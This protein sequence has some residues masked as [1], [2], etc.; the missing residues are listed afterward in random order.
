MYYSLYGVVG[1]EFL[2]LRSEIWNQFLEFESNVG[3]MASIIKVEKRR[4]QAL[5]SVSENPLTAKKEPLLFPSL[6]GTLF[7]CF[8]HFLNEETFSLFSFS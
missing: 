5:Q 2:F 4:A 7:F 1:I 3:D 8:S 6:T